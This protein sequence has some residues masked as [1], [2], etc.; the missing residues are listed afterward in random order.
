MPSLPTRLQAGAR[1]ESPLFADGRRAVG[2]G[3][4]TVSMYHLVSVCACCVGGYC[5][6]C[7]VGSQFCGVYPAVTWSA[8]V[9]E[10]VVMGTCRQ[11]AC[12][13]RLRCVVFF[14]GCAPVAFVFPV[15][16]LCGACDMWCGLRGRVVPTCMLVR[17]CH[18]VLACVAWVCLPL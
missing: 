4:C 9:Q 7:L 12:T 18:C 5:M 11:P 13:V 17:Q 2:T 16:P 10:C 14:P 3:R 8:C 15:E 1:V 6:G